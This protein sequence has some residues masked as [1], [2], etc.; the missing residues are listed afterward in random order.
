MIPPG[1]DD[2]RRTLEV[3]VPS[4]TAVNTDLGA[5]Y[6]RVIALAE[7]RPENAPGADKSWISTMDEAF[8]RHYRAARPG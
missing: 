5:D 7:A 4:S 6:S 2:A 8:R 1:R 3:V